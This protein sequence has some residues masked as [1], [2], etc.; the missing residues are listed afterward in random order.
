VIHGIHTLGPWLKLLVAR[1][2]D[3]QDPLITLPVSISAEIAMPVSDAGS[4]AVN[5]YAQQAKIKH[6]GWLIPPQ[7]S[8]PTNLG[9]HV[10][11]TCCCHDCV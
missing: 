4:I 6:A 5:A 7:Y 11:V 10:T 1:H 8:Q 3:P 9:L 2:D